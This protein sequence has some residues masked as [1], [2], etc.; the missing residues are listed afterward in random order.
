MDTN[1]CYRHAE[2]TKRMQIYSEIR[3]EAVVVV[4]ATGDLLLVID[5]TNIL[6]SDLFLL[7]ELKWLMQHICF[8]DFGKI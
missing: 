6:A 4:H 8:T 1:V 2:N 5:F 3:R 7:I